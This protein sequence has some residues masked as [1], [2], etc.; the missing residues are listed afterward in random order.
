MRGRNFQSWNALMAHD[1]PKR[2]FLSFRLSKITRQ[3]LDYL[4][5]RWGENQSRCIVRAIERAA[6]DEKSKT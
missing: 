1:K 5:K 4:I 6:E 3:Q 2:E